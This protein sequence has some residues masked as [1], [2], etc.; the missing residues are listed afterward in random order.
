M[1]SPFLLALLASTSTLSDAAPAPI[2]EPPDIDGALLPRACP[3]GQTAP[4]WNAEHTQCR[5]MRCMK[6]GSAYPTFVTIITCA[7]G[8]GCQL[9]NGL[10]KCV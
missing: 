6:V 5:W 10:P 2:N 3:I 9:V 4:V 1:R 8:T 7:V